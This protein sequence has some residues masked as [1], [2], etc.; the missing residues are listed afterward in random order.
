MLL[1]LCP[2]YL[3]QH[4]LPHNEADLMAPAET[5]KWGSGGRATSHALGL[6]EP[7]GVLFTVPSDEV[8][9]GMIIG[10][11]AREG[12]LDVNPVREKKLTNMRN[13]GSEE[14]VHLSPPRYDIDNA[15]GLWE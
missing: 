2:A 12:D 6:L 7:R 5:C 14:K 1:S 8:Y 15:W 4:D 13:T 11:H 9:E 10:E 3:S